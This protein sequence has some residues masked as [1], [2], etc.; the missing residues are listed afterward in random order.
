M[1]YDNKMS[2]LLFKAKS[3]NPRAPKLKGFFEDENGKKYELAAW[4][5]TDRE[6]DAP[7]K[8]KN[9]NTYLSIKL[10]FPDEPKGA[11]QPREDDEP[12]F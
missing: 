7:R 12:A 9:G 4:L 8:D 2:G 5:V 11:P 3:N 10:S 1:A 6:T